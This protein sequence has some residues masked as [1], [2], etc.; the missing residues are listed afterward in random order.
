VPFVE[1]TRGG[2]DTHANNF[3]LVRSLSGTLDR[4]WATLLADLADR[5]LLDRTLVVWMGEF[6]RTP[7]I[8]PRNG[9]DH[10]PGAWS[11]VLG[12]G[13]IKGGQVVGRTS[14]DGLRVEDRPVSAPDLMATICLALGLDP[15]KQNPSNVDRPIRLAD[16]SAKPVKE[17]LA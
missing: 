3:E 17:V 12:G 15:R 11:V 9:R 8:N 1:V 6:G 2:W 5:G 14:K 4:A 16:P 10:Y 7:K 13:G